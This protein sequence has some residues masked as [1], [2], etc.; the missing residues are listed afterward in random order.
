MAHEDR[1]EV[2]KYI[3]GTPELL[4]MLYDVDLLPEQTMN[5]SRQ[6]L[7]TLLVVRLHRRANRWEICT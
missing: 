4:S 2:L 3:N 7:R 5:D 1:A 6:W